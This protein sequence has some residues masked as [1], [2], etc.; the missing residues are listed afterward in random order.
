MT[1][2]EAE[3]KGYKEGYERALN[4]VIDTHKRLNILRIK[5]R[6]WK[7]GLAWFFLMAVVIIGWLEFERG[8]MVDIIEQQRNMIDKAWEVNSIRAALMIKYIRD[9]KSK[10]RLTPRKP[11]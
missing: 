8:K 9:T 1:V 11:I 3:L 5:L 7:E 4:E 2:D 10:K 6:A